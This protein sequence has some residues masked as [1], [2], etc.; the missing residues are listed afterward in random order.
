MVQS[1]SHDIYIQ[2]IEYAVF[3]PTHTCSHMLY[4]NTAITDNTCQICALGHHV[5]ILPTSD[6][7]P[8]LKQE[9]LY[10]HTHI[11]LLKEI[12]WLHMINFICFAGLNFVLSITLD[13]IIVTKTKYNRFHICMPPFLFLMP[14]M[15][16]GVQELLG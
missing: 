15:M 2:K 7:F 14:D 1:I 5:M 10:F 13:I 12:F 8:D 16:V 9:N 4:N 6:F 3:L 11:S